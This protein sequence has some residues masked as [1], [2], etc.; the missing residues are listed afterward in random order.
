VIH[1]LARAENDQGAVPDSLAMPHMLLLLRHS[2]E[3][4]TAFEQIINGMHNPGSPNYQQ[5]LTAEE[6]GEQFGPA[7]ADVAIVT[8]WLES[9]G[10]RVNAVY[11]NG[12]AIDR[13][14]VSNYVL[15]KLGAAQYG[16]NSRPNFLGLIFCDANLGFLVGQDCIFHDISVGDNS[17]SCVAGSP[18]CF[19]PA[20]AAVGVLS[21]ST[22]SLQPAFRAMPGWDF[23]TGL[24]SPNVAN[25]VN[26]W[27]AARG[28]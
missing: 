8:A 22:T 9:H 12:L 21:T 26:S 25:L 15:Y 23:A 7:Q 27:P 24:G 28:H 3:Q 5:W 10:F 4:E 6:I 1:P 16:S 13:Q 19:A 2:P 11:P 20:G 17:V 14:G 18:N